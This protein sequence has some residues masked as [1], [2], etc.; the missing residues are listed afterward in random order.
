MI[1]ARLSR[2][3]TSNRPLIGLDVTAAMTCALTNVGRLGARPGD[4]PFHGEP[5]AV[6]PGSVRAG[7]LAGAMV[8]HSNQVYRPK[9]KPCLAGTGL[10][11][12]LL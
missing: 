10:L 7:G 1:L 12:A 8:L 11:C 9:P 5:M 6:N 3:Y 2:V 4:C